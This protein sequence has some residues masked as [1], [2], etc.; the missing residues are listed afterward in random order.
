M[1]ISVIIII[2]AYTV[3]ITAKSFDSPET[4]IA[5]VLAYF[6]LAIIRTAVVSSASITSEKEARTWP[7][8][9]STPLEKKDIARGKIIAS[10]IKA[11]PFWTLM[12][13]HLI[14]FTSLH[15]IHP[16][17]LPPLAI[18][19][20]FS[21]LA[22]SSIGVFISSCCKR[23]A[24]SASV[25]MVVVFIYMGINPMPF[26]GPIFISAIILG[27]AAD[28][29]V[30][31]TSFMSLDFVVN[32]GVEQFLISSAVFIGIMLVYLL[33]AYVCYA[34]TQSNIRSNIF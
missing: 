2:A 7:I 5:F 25:N 12:A 28:P 10:I 14:V 16:F 32:I 31:L 6:F 8:L 27:A 19:F 18:L 29:E 4:H 13:L 22:T 3:C 21:A 23:T 11:W 24:V 34:V 33:V 9:L 30:A 15:Y 26:A 1:T 20:L 17:A